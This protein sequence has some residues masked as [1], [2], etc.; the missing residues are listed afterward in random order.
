MEALINEDERLLEKVEAGD[1]PLL[2]F[3]IGMVFSRYIARLLSIIIK[4]LRKNSK[5]T[6]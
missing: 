4:Y 5:K 6:L 3:L 1:W 2:A